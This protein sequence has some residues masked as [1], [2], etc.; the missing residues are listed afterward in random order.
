MRYLV[1]I[2]GVCSNLFGRFS[3]I[4]ENETDGQ[5]CTQP[6]SKFMDLLRAKFD[7]QRSISP[8]IQGREE[9]LSPW[10]IFL[11]ALRNLLRG[12][13]FG[14]RFWADQRMRGFAVPQC[15]DSPPT[16]ASELDKM[17]FRA[18]MLKAE[19]G[20]DATPGDES[21]GVSDRL[22]YAEWFTRPRSIGPCLNTERESIIRTG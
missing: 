22:C 2:I 12:T 10:K 16:S 8:Y 5:Y 19:V 11:V 6:D 18:G 7:F 21:G 17:A 13:G 4:V 9:E 14:Q 15:A 1:H 3:G 20:P